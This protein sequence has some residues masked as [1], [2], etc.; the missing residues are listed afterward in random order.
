MT[1]TASACA[2]I[3]LCG[4]HAVVYGQPAIALPLSDVRVM[5][6][7]ESAETL[8]F[9][10]QD[11]NET[12]DLTQPHPIADLAARLCAAFNVPPPAVAIHLT[13]QIP[14]ASGLG[15]GAAIATAVARLLCQICQRPA[16]PDFINPLV[17]ESE[18]QFHGTPSGIDNTV[19]AYEQPVYFVRGYPIERLDIQGQYSLLIGDTGVRAPTHIPVGDVR[20]LVEADTAHLSHTLN[21]I[22]QISRDIHRALRKHQLKEMG[23][24]MNENHRLLQKLTVSSPELDTLVSAAQVAGAY[25]AKM[26]GGGRG[27]NMI[28]LVSEETKPAVREA[29]MQAGAVRVLETTLQGWTRQDTIIP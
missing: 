14:I 9:V 3:I 4:E 27:G 15:S 28:A 1:Y 12:F 26:S 2:K 19:I 10:L 7:A 23:R 24:A 17:Y 6:T 16:D 29:L 13:S 20:R 25:G 11:L 18:K 22:G 21:R 5:A 8:T